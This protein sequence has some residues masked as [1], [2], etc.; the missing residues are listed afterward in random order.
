MKYSVNVILGF[1]ADFFFF[2]NESRALEGSQIKSKCTAQRLYLVSFRELGIFTVLNICRLKI[3][4]SV[5]QCVV[6]EFTVSYINW[7][8][9]GHFTTLWGFLY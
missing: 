9:F 8:G 5:P 3:N 6:R 7:S 4:M 1:Q 2:F